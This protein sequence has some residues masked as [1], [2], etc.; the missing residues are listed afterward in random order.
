[1]S[2]EVDR[3]VEGDGSLDLVYRM[4]PMRLIAGHDCDDV[5]IR[6][7]RSRHQGHPTIPEYMSEPA[8]LHACA[9]L[10]KSKNCNYERS[11]FVP[12][13]DLYAQYVKYQ[14]GI[15]TGNSEVIRSSAFIR[16]RSRKNLKTE[17]AMAIGAKHCGLRVQMAPGC[18][19]VA[20]R[21]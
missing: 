21:S 7:R 9:R 14:S 2:A 13:A 19:D 3:A 4:V 5:V 12:F 16:G 15:D 8:H 1:V 17:F 11:P 20:M 10:A 6:R 18:S